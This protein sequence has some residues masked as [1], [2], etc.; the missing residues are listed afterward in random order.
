MGYMGTEPYPPPNYH[1]PIQALCDD[2][3]LKVVHV[4]HHFGEPS[5]QNFID[6]VRDE[7]RYGRDKKEDVEVEVY[8]GSRLLDAN[9]RLSGW[10]T[11]H[12]RFRR[13]GTYIVL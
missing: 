7:F 2:G 9:E 4:W 13:N 8:E 6:A 11:Y 5:V 1:Q 10:R 3:S 12:V